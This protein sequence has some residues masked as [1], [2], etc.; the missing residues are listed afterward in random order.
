MAYLTIYPTR[1]D[2]L[3]DINAMELPT[4][5]Y[6]SAKQTSSTTVDSGRDASGVLY[7]DRVLERDLVKIEIKWAWLRAEVW[8]E[9]LQKILQG[10]KQFY[11]YIRYF[12]MTTNDFRILQFYPSDRSATPFKVDPVTHRTISYLDCSVNFIDTGEKEVFR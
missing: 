4:P 11:V 6:S 10:D 12:D 7:A 3:N 2:A 5:S 8:A 9:I 1:H